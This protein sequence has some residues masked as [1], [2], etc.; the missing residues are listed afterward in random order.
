MKAAGITDE[1]FLDA[2]RTVHRERWGSRGVTAATP[3][4][5]DNI[6][7]IGASRWD[8]AAVLDGHPEW[9]GRA[10][11]TDGFSVQIPAWVVLAKAKSLERRGLIAGCC[12]GC[13]GDFQV[14]SPSG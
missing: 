12:C 1:A 13:R 9:C 6:H 8:I 11:A 4:G 5:V 7:W 14:M 10:E 3:L 2:I